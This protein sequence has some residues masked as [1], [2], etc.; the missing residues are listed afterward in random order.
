MQRKIPLSLIEVKPE[1][2]HQ[3]WPF[4]RRGLDLIVRRIRPDWI[5]ENIFAALQAGQTNCVISARGQRPIGF[6]VYYRQ[7]RPF[8]GKAEL[9]IWAAW[10]LPIRESR[11]DDDLPEMVALVWRYLEQVAISNYKTDEITW[12]TSA[13]RAKAFEA[14]YGWKPR[15]V[16]FQIKAAGV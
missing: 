6:V 5:A 14:K 11:P 4:I 16:T 12:G 3:H 1:T 15:F 10:D 2:L 8:S 13:S 7:V 9:F